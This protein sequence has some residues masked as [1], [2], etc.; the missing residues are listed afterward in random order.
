MTPKGNAEFQT[1]ADGSRKFDAE[2]EDVNLP[3]GTVLNVLVN[4]NKVG[5]LTLMTQRGELELKSRDGQTVPPITS[6]SQVNITDQANHL[7][8]SGTFSVVPP[9]PSPTPTASPSPNGSPTAT[10]TPNANAGVRLES[11]LAGSAIDGLTPKGHAKFVA[12][13][14]GRRKVEVEAEKVNLPSGTLLNVM[15][16][17]A[18]VGQITLGNGLEGRVELDTQKGN[19]VPNVTTSSTIVITNP[20]NATVL[21]GVFNTVR[22]DIAGND[23]DDDAIFVEQHY[24]DVLDREGDDNGVDFWEHQIANCG[25]DPA[26][27]EQ[28]RINTSGA[29]FLSIEFQDTGYLLYRLN[30]ASFGT[31]PRR[32]DFLVE[33]ERVAQGVVVNSPG[34]QQKLADNKQQEA[35]RWASRQDFHDRFDN[36]SNRDFVN[37][38]FANAGVTPDQTEI[39]NLVK[40]LD[41]GTETRGS[42]LR[43]IA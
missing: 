17:N 13:P 3:D 41:A 11:R 12:R 15:I 28:T 22:N 16:D 23:I 35:E 8:L 42:A 37:T 20:Q 5:T 27:R 1:F 29:F 14:D 31:M 21:S 30:K 40:G 36:K 24:N 34:W 10:P 18:A 7:I 39:E 25:A 6:G 26:C 2:A 38:L 19:T 32:N 9:A 33:M 43:K 4:G